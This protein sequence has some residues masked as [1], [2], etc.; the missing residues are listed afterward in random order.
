MTRSRLVTGSRRLSIA[1]A[2]CSS[3]SANVDVADEVAVSVATASATAV[4]VPMISDL[5]DGGVAKSV[6][7][8]SADDI[9]DVV[10]LIAVVV[11]VA[12]AVD[13]GPQVEVASAVALADLEND[14]NAIAVA[15]APN[16]AVPST[17]DTVAIA[18]GS[19]SP[20]S[21]DTSTIGSCWSVTVTGVPQFAVVVVAS[22]VFVVF[23]RFRCCN[24]CCFGNCL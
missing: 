10:V 17:A 22:V 6:L 14:P 13:A 9:A 19:S 21:D 1:R 7:D 5:V 12:D 2:H 15:V 23:C 4:S 16:G 20:E 3:A 11:A 18:S 24:D 8:A